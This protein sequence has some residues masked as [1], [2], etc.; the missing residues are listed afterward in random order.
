LIS[1]GSLKN[2]LKFSKPIQFQSK[3]VHRVKA[4]KNEIA[5]GT[6]KKMVKMTAA[7]R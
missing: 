2:C 4:K 3:R 5:V 7:G 1:A 6:R